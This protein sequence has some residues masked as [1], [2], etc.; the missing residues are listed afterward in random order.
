[1]SEKEDKE[2]IECFVFFFLKNFDASRRGLKL[3]FYGRVGVAI[4][5]I[6]SSHPQGN[7]HTT[8]RYADTISHHQHHHQEK[9]RSLKTLFISEGSIPRKERA[10]LQKGKKRPCRCYF[11]DS[12]SLKKLITN[13]WNRCSLLRRG[14]VQWKKHTIV[15]FQNLLSE[16]TRF[17]IFLH[18]DGRQEDDI[19][20]LM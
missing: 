8:R 5:F 2:Y 7:H 15:V 9:G 19:A 14:M 18:V 10:L 13:V 16:L 11:S 17:L 20:L 4:S 6:H 12:D 3:S 1:M